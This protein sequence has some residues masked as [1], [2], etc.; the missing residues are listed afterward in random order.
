METKITIPESVIKKACDKAYKECS[1]NAYFDNGFRK[2]VE[3]TLENLKVVEML[4]ML[5]VVT[6]TISFEKDKI[7]H[8]NSENH[9]TNKIEQLI[10]EIAESTKL[11]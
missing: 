1:Y 5:K 9:W 7:S 10:K 3:F 2:G 8:G 6:M 4:E 11:K